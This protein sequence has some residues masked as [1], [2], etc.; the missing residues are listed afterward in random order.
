MPKSSNFN[1]SSLPL[2]SISFFSCFSLLF[3]IVSRFL[4]APRG[5]PFS[6]H[7][8]T[9][10]AST[11]AISSLSFFICRSVEMGILANELCAMI[12]PSQSPRATFETNFLRLSFSK[13]SFVATRI[14]AFGYSFLHSPAHCRTRWFGQVTI[15]FLQSPN[16]RIFIIEAMTVKVL[17]APTTW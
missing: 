14:C 8:F 3:F 10:V 5:I 2:A 17:P 1:T 7:C 11:P 12:M 6:S 4:T 13:S 16:C 9:I 15:A